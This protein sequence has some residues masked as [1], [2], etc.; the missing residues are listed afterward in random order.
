MH[1]GNSSG[2]NH[3][4]RGGHG[5][6]HVISSEEMDKKQQ[7]SSGRIKKNTLNDQ[8]AYVDMDAIFGKALEGTFD[9]LTGHPGTGQLKDAIEGR[10]RKNRR[11]TIDWPSKLRRF[12]RGSFETGKTRFTTPSKFH[13]DA[14][15]KRRVERIKPVGRK[16]VIFLDTSGSVF[17]VPGVIQQFLTEVSKI[18]S[19]ENSFRY[20]D[21]IPFNGDIDWDSLIIEQPKS[22]IS[23]KKWTLSNLSTGGTVYDCV[24]NF[25]NDYYIDHKDLEDNEY[26][27]EE[28]KVFIKHKPNCILIVSDCDVHGGTNMF[29]EW[30]KQKENK[31]KGEAIIRSFRGKCCFLGLY[32]VQYQN[33]LMGDTEPEVYFKEACIPGTKAIATPY[34]DFLKYL[35]PLEDEESDEDETNENYII[36]NK[37]KKGYF[38]INEGFKKKGTGLGTSSSVTPPPTPPVDPD[39]SENSDEPSDASSDQDTAN[40]KAKNSALFNRVRGKSKDAG[41]LLDDNAFVEDVDDWV[42]EVLVP[43][44]GLTK[45]PNE[46]Q[47]RNLAQSY[48]IDADGRVVINNQMSR[49]GASAN[50]RHSGR[51]MRYSRFEMPAKAFSSK[52][53]NNGPIIKRYIGSLTINNFSGTELPRF[54]PLQIKSG[55]NGGDFIIS[56]C[57]N[58]SSTKNMPEYVDHRVTI[59]NTDLAKADV[60]EYRRLIID[61]W[62]S[63]REKNGLPTD[64]PPKVIANDIFENKADTMNNRQFNYLV[65]SR[66][67]L[68]RRYNKQDKPIMKI[69]ET[70]GRLDKQNP[71]YE[72]I[73]LELNRIAKMPDNK[74]IIRRLTN[75]LQGMRW[76]DLTADMVDV[77]DKPSD[78]HSIA[79]IIP[80]TKQ[81]AG[82][83]QFGIIIIT[84]D[85]DK[86]TY[87]VAGNSAK[88]DTIYT[89]SE[90]LNILPERIKLSGT[91]K[92]I[93]EKYGINTG[94]FPKDDKAGV[95]L[96]EFCGK[97]IYDTICR[98]KDNE[99]TPDPR[100]CIFNIDNFVNEGSGDTYEDICEFA[101]KI[102]ERGGANRNYYNTAKGKYE[103]IKSVKYDTNTADSLN[104]KRIVSAYGAT[105]N[106][107]TIEYMLNE[108]LLCAILKSASIRDRKAASLFTEPDKDY[109]VYTP[110]EFEQMTYEELCDAYDSMRTMNVRNSLL[111]NTGV[112]TED[113]SKRGALKITTTSQYINGTY[114]DVESVDFTQFSLL[115]LVPDMAS[116]LYWIH[117]SDAGIRKRKAD[118]TIPETDFE[119]IMDIEDPAERAEALRSEETAD[120]FRS[121]FYT[122]GR[123]PSQNNPYYKPAKLA[124][125]DEDPK[126]AIEKFGELTDKVRKDVRSGATMTKK[127]RN[128]YNARMARMAWNADHDTQDAR[129]DTDKAKEQYDKRF[130]RMYEP[131]S[132]SAVPAGRKLDVKG[133]DAYAQFIRNFNT[134]TGT[135]KDGDMRCQRMYRK[136]VSIGSASPEFK[137]NIVTK[138]YSSIYD[139]VSSL[140]RENLQYGDQDANLRM[141]TA[142]NY[143]LGGYD[144][145]GNLVSWFEEDNND[146]IEAVN[147]QD[148][149]LMKTVMDRMRS[150]IDSMSKFGD[151]HNV[152]IYHTSYNSVFKA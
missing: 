88:A 30:A 53:I 101:A 52:Y 107:M 131:D 104:F 113:D 78:Y 22:T 18:A 17:C 40:D 147:E 34:E 15:L 57:M 49:F 20:Y 106:P 127:E 98:N 2:N 97:I 92:K 118:P 56:N 75:E 119:D 93:F 150:R 137:Q 146:I 122:R 8:G 44:W 140:R 81:I 48:A 1:D 42:K 10:I 67:N 5:A 72:S 63:F 135:T 95:T 133:M 58:L 132:H 7:S 43:A 14:A 89:D 3:S 87:I 139:I 120:L 134:F 148:D 21:I 33:A 62:M 149:A 73:P 90:M 60:D 108:E 31:A 100:T 110:D 47:C 23:G 70:F 61:N 54:I 39:D 99:Y 151:L 29:N 85:N 51:E 71:D 84:D 45:A 116:R 9:R 64:N 79:K 59:S 121:H 115:L 6:S 26:N 117:N 36:N 77:Y 114:Q 102:F 111:Y 136:I 65:E 129:F 82:R 128:E 144:D 112:K 46:M 35:D 69:D 80:G 13:P 86:I 12:F 27:S 4:I 123:K 38:V 68:A 142:A 94:N 16:L 19:G 74:P 109:P 141:L 145:K 105:L 55:E 125:W 32:P 25:I 83:G 124:Q 143:L 152:E 50:D 41:A 138:Y 130:A 11:S 96:D 37:M 126:D 91:T 66:R 76:G 28:E 103:V 24:Y